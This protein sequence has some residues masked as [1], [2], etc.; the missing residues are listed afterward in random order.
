MGHWALGNGAFGGA[1][2]TSVAVQHD[3]DAAPI[4]SDQKRRGSSS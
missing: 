1:S 3:E 2:V 4:W